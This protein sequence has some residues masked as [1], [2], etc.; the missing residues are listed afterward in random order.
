MSAQHV[1][2]PDATNLTPCAATTETP[3]EREAE[4]TTTPAPAVT[5]DQPDYG[6]PIHPV[7]D[8]FPLIVGDE[9][10]DLY[11]D[12]HTHGLTNPIVIHE[13]CIVD[14]RN[15]LLACRDAGVAPRFVEW[16]DV[17][18]GEQSL[19]DWIWSM[20]GARRHLTVEQ[21]GGIWAD[22]N[23]FREWEAARQRQRD[24]A[25]RGGATAGKGRPKTAS[26]DSDDSLMTKPSEGSATAIGTTV[27]GQMTEA[28][29]GLSEYKAQQI[30][31]LHK[32][33]PELLKAVTQGTKTLGEATKELKA[34]DADADMWDTNEIPKRT[35]TL[36]RW[37]AMTV[38]EREGVIASADPTATKG[39]NEQM[40]DSIEWA[41]FSWNPV[42]G[43]KH[44]CPYCYARDIAYRFYP[45]KFEPSLMPDRLA[46]P[47]NKKPSKQADLDTSYK[48]IFT[49]SMADLFGSW[50][51][52]EWIEAVLKTARAAPQWNFLFL[53]KF[54]QRLKEFE[55]PDNCW[56]GT[57]IDMQARVP[58]AERAMRDV[59][60]KTKWLSLEPLIEPL[61][62]D[63]SIFN[64]VVVGGA[65]LS[66]HTPAWQPPRRWVRD[67]WTAAEKAG[68]EVYLKSNLN[69]ERWL[70][71][72]WCPC[73]DVERA[74]EVFQYLKPV[75]TPATPD[76]LVQN[77]LV[78]ISV[79][80]DPK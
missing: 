64:W 73:R 16:R 28:V 9:F 23:R 37:E 14:G 24:G 58:N 3:I 55:F 30:L 62:I 7:S 78:Q 33:D 68:C 48:N 65:T 72:P 66:S 18:D 46:T 70:S 59:R 47:L 1:P 32:K 34:A 19:I 53:T 41:R 26:S 20:N 49:C 15:R 43:F 36:P 13:G 74:P 42:T 57:S 50:V 51:P 31:N 75:R 38:A 69:T 44:D 10:L 52:R 40:G 4:T 12:I 6:M 11:V 63:F 29:P 27:R 77:D 22:V 8:L 5:A 67:I 25:T 80:A 76:D 79:S 35:I 60:A 39:W 45:Q 21:R 2:A 71:F 61:E 54:P 17:Y 56:L